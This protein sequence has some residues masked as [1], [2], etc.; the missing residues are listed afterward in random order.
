MLQTIVTMIYSLLKS[1]TGKK[2]LFSILIDPENFSKKDLD[3][4]IKIANNNNIDFILI[5]GSLIS[6]S[7]DNSIQRIKSL[8]RIPVLLFPGSLHQLSE[9]ADGILLLSL[10]SGRN[11]EHLIGNHVLA[12]PILKKMNIEVISTGYILVGDSETSAVEYISNT[13][14]IPSHKKDIVVA[15]AL[16]GE[17][18]GNQVMYLEGGS[19]A[20]TPI[21]PEIITA[22]RKNIAVPL[23]VGGGISTEKDALKAYQAGAD[24][25]VVGNAIESKPGL[26]E[27]IKKITLQFSNV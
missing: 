26:I 4:T 19:G 6:E 27:Q 11:P 10:I 7:L 5:G 24:M 21:P 8:T 16:A 14:P 3:H 17:M 1:I 23:I 18:I 20:K 12:A 25:I 22:V 13:I 15:T 9:M 2:K